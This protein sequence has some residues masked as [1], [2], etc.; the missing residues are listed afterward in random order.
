[1]RTK[2]F[3]LT[4]AAPGRVYERGCRDG[5][6]TA[7]PSLMTLP[8]TLRRA[9][10]VV[11]LA[12]LTTVAGCGAAPPKSG[13]SG[14]DGLVIPTPSAN[15]AD[16]RAAVDNPWLPLAP[17]STWEYDV[18]GAVDTRSRTVTVA[19]QRVEISGIEATAVRSV[20]RDGRGRVR[21]DTAEWFAQDRAGNVWKL[22]EQTK[23]RRATGLAVTVSW[24][25]GD[26]GAQAGVVMLAKPRVGDGYQHEIATGVAEDRSSIVTLDAE[27]TVPSGSY[28]DALETEDTSALTPSVEGESYYARG[29][30]LVLASVAGVEVQLVKFTPAT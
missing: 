12:A 5:M 15:P 1:M 17:G 2:R 28:D 19:N 24:R 20:E 6:L 22:G 11:L 14:V 26:G 30:G 13:P 9:G 4:L 27:V 16:F 10:S 18:R 8:M 7:M 29:I 23:E 25:A 21:L 3:R